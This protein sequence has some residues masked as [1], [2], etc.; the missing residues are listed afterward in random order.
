MVSRVFVRLVAVA[1]LP[2]L[3]AGCGGG[4]RRF[5]LREPMLRDA[6]VAPVALPCRPDPKHPGR[7]TC[8]PSSYE[9]SF[10]WDAADNTVFRPI[11][12]ALA[13]DPGGEAVNVNSFDEVPDSS[14]FTNRI[15]ANP[16]AAEQVARGFCEEGELDPEA[17]DGSWVIDQG[18]MNGA[19]P[20]FRI[21]DPRGVR[22]MLKPDTR[23]EPERATGATAVATRFYYA[24]GWWAPCD[25]VVYFRPSILKLS[26][27]L[28]ITDNTGHTKPLDEAALRAMLKDASRR[29]DRIRMVASRW[30]P[31]H[32][33]GPFRY[34]GLRDDDPNDAIPH[35]DRRDLRGARLIA[36]WL[37]HFDS[38][39]QN[40]MDTWMPVNE[41]D[42]ASPGYVR[43]WYL[44]LGDCFGSRWS[45]DDIS[46]RLG[47]AYYFDAGYVA[48]DFVTL[49]IVE[50]PW[51]RAETHGTFGYFS[52]KD[53]DPSAWRGGYPNPAFGRM[54]EHDGAWIA[55]II[56]RFS[57]ALV[58]AAVSAGDFT[59]PEDAT[60]LTDALVARQRA[61]LR[62]YLRDLSPLT[63][64]RIEGGDGLCALDVARASGA[65]HDASFHYT[66]TSYIGER[67]TPRSLAERLS[68]GGRACTRLIHRAPDNGP[69]DDAASRYEIVD[70]WNGQARF[71]LR[72]HLYDLGPR[73]G[74]R[75]VG[76]ERPGSVAPPN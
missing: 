75:L 22:Y 48:E 50:R 59:N 53:F 28:S 55:R 40:T 46:R 1:A 3:L 66:A 71:P 56:A 57:R 61:I 36:A 70:I 74:F 7:A 23:E 47:H 52:A 10:A 34:E 62:R 13:A 42:P 38:R 12:R 17:P 73:R 15:G 8:A 63:D 35:E 43:H 49:G 39:E 51:D 2:L 67:S 11:A 65:F 18:K 30:L 54:T 45:W 19:N 64:A 20:G 72:A 16:L 58:A 60:F 68:R 21:K 26:P 69:A 37:N 24:A 76:V 32:P 5:P 14:W 31:G 4:L 44:D 27:G 29:G 6:D 33:I 9:S 25:K 41:K